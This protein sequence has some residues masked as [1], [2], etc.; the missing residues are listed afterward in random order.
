MAWSED[1]DSTNLKREATDAGNVA[2]YTDEAEGKVVL[3]YDNATTSYSEYA[4]DASGV[5]VDTHYGRYIISEGD[6]VCSGVMVGK[7]VSQHS[8]SHN[9][10]FSNL[11]P[12][13]NGWDLWG[14]GI[15]YGPDGVSPI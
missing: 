7:R 4:W 14:S 12:D 1:Y 11:D 8:Y 15:Y 10:E 13:T 6:P 3:L 5:V 2:E 9:D